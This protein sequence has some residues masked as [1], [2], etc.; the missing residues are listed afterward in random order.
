MKK[1]LYNKFT[2]HT[3]V[4]FVHVQEVVAIYTT[5]AAEKLSLPS[6]LKYANRSQVIQAFLRNKTASAGEI[7]TMIGLSRPTVM[8]AIQFFLSNGLLVS[9]GKGDSTCIGGKRPER[10]ALS[11]EKFFLCIALWPNDLRLH[12][13]TIGGDLIDSIRLSPPLPESAWTAAND[14]GK[15]SE[16]LL[17][18]N[19]VSRED[20]L[21]VSLS[22]A[23]IVD[24]KTGLL[25]YSS[26]SP[27]W[28]TDSPLWEYLRPYFAQDTMIFLENAG[29]M[30]ARPLLLEPELTGKRILVIFAC[31]GLSSCMIE[32]NHI[33]SGKNSLIGEI[34]HMIIDPHDSEPCGCGSRGC[35]ERLVSAGRLQRL[36]KEQAARFP[37]SALLRQPVEDLTIPGVFAASE[38]GDPLARFLTEYLAENFTQ[39]LRNISLVFDPDLVVFQGDYAY[40]DPYFDHCL[41]ENLSSFRYFPSS[42]PFDIRYDR[43]PLNELDALGSY[44]ALMDQFFDSPE[45]YRDSRAGDSVAT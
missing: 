37:E 34:G 43:R 1:L 20:V 8:K 21:A 31:W 33:L 26:Q 42:A 2:K 23:G 12:L 15:L 39:A 41:R 24:R 30:T 14:A 45:L 38:T 19:R 13:Y 18:K 11:G 36:L 9:A 25:K 44:I 40:A 4:L 35:F 3:S 10:F 5:V 27:S 28:G 7:S 16:T 6:D 17:A 22:T 32:K 29:K